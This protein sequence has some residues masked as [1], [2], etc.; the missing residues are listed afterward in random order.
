LSRSCGDGTASLVTEISAPAS[1]PARALLIKM[2]AFVAGC[3]GMSNSVA[4]PVT[5]AMVQSAGGLSAETLQQGRRI[6]AGP[7]TSCHTADPVGKYSVAEWRAIVDDDMGDR[8]R[9]NS[10]ERSALI[11]YISAAH[12][13]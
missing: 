9:L 1:A 6:F 5:A 13:R 10:A 12:A 4:P 11:A 3:A 7:C 8:A 2:A